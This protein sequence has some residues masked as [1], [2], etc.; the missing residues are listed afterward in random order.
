MNVQPRAGKWQLRVKHALLPKPYFTT[1]DTEAEARGHGQQIEALLA[2]G[3]VPAELLAPAPVSRA[4]DPLLNQVIREYQGLAPVTT[5]DDE[6]LAVITVEVGTVRVSGVTVRWA[7]QYVAGLKTPERNLAP[8]TIRKRIGAL[9]RV[10]DWHIGRAHNGDA[11]NVLRLL[12]RGYSLYTKAETEAARAKGLDAKVDVR[13]DYRVPLDEQARIQRVLDG[14]KPEGRQRGL[15]PDPEFTLLFRVIIDTGLRLSEAFKLRVDQLEAPARL[16]H[17]E[18]SK[19]HRGAIKPRTVPLKRAVLDALVAWCE[20][21]EGL[22]FPGLWDGDPE[23][24]RRASKRLTLRF[25]KAFELAGLPHLTEHDLRHEATCRWVLLRDAS[26]RWM[27]SDIEVCRIMGWTNT[28]LMLRY[29]SLRGEDLSARF[30][31]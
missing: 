29:A 7:E 17:V 25:Q 6:L 23:E 11:V 9:G 14:E 16:L 5:S 20:G 3:I 26:G 22:M 27:F 1:W 19:G 4:D 30:V 2:R 21:R 10:L 24:V 31:D 28:N 15:T 13:R 8:G 18:G 12:P